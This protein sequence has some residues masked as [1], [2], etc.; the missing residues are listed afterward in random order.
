MA[1][2]QMAGSNGGLDVPNVRLYQLATH[3]RVIA[4]WF[5]YD[6]APIWLVIESSQSKCPLWNLL[7]VNNSGSIKDLCTNPIL[8]STVEA[9]RS[10]CAIEGRAELTSP[11]TPILDGPDFLPCCQDLSFKAWH[12]QGQQ[13]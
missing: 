6:P 3:L 11:L 12:S 13:R 1:K 5:K 10:I 4:D 9:W 7:F 8:S 2:L